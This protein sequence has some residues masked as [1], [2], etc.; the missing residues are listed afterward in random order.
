MYY[1]FSPQLLESFKNNKEQKQGT[2]TIKRKCPMPGCELERT[3]LKSHLMN[4]HR[5]PAEKALAFINIYGQR[6]VRERK[7]RDQRKAKARTYQRKYCPIGE[8][9]RPS[10]ARLDNHLRQFHKIPDAIQRK[11]LLKLALPVTD[12]EEESAT[13]SSSSDESAAEDVDKIIT[14]FGIPADCSDDNT[15]DDEWLL[16]SVQRKAE[17]G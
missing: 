4:I 9:P 11:N 7:S 3:N 6:K 14:E 17:G 10:Q 2:K 1:I 16:Q 13:E 15:S 5:V 12:G 8:C